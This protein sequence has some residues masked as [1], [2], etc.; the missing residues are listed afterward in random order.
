MLSILELTIESSALVHLIYLF[1]N[2]L[3]IQSYE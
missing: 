2:T 1:I 3:L